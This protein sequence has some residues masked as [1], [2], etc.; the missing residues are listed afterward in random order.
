MEHTSIPP[1]MTNSAGNWQ[2]D[3]NPTPPGQNLP[4][5]IVEPPDKPTTGPDAPVNEPEPVG[6]VRQ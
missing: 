1:G 2:D 6:P 5:P 3:P 4:V